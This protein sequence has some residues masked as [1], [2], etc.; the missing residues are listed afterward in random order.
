M[1]RRK[2]KRNII[3]DPG[4]LGNTLD[5]E[6]FDCYAKGKKKKDLVAFSKHG[7]MSKAAKRTDGPFDLQSEEF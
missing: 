5:L 1:G 2:C 4:V 3:R 6:G 7:E